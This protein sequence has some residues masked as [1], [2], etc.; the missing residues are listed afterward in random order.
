MDDTYAVILAAGRGKRLAPLTNHRP[1]AMLP[2][3]GK[4]LIDYTVDQFIQAGIRKFIIVINPQ[5]EIIIDYF[6]KKSVGVDIIFVFQS[7][8]RGMGDALSCAAGY[9]SS[10]FMLSACDNLVSPKDIRRILAT[11]QKTKAKAI[12]ALMAVKPE[13]F[14]STAI[15][16]MNGSQVTNIIE[17]PS[18][19]EAP[20]NIA[21]LPLYYFS[22]DILKYIPTIQPS[23][24][25]EY[26]LQDAIQKLIQLD[27]NVFGITLRNRLTLT[28]PQDLLEIN[29]LYLSKPEYIST[30]PSNNITDY[31]YTPPVYIEEGVMIGKHSSIGP[32]VYIEKG[33]KIGCEASIEN[34]IILENVNLS[35]GAI[36]HN[37]LVYE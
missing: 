14:S 27:G 28:T 20:S 34:S 35:S 19:E 9:L 36:I 22:P 23:K 12:L 15:V 6:R 8:P 13:N 32:K 18:S 26:E 11:R 30:I 1:K 21:S 5:S 2:I 4:P 16:E 37:Q 7:E 31:A 17:K 24:R 3:L 10:D 29:L 25:G 33:A